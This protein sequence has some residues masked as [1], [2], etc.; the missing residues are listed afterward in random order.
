M[1]RNNS[2]RCQIAVAAMILTTSIQAVAEVPEGYYDR[3]EG[4]NKGELLDALESIVGDH[5]DVGYKK[6]WNVFKESDVKATA[7]TASTPCPKVG[8]TKQVP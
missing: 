5:T 6:I 7:T 3:A 1:T 2:F 4:L 8:L